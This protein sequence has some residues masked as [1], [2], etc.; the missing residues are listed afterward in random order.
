MPKNNKSQKLSYTQLNKIKLEA[1]ARGRQTVLQRRQ[2]QKQA[3]INEKEKINKM[4]QNEK[5]VYNL[6]KDLKIQ[7]QND[8]ALRK[9]IGTTKLLDK[10]KTTLS[11]NI[12][13][14]SSKAKNTLMLSIS[15]SQ[16]KPEFS[17][18]TIQTFGNNL[19]RYF[20]KI[21]LNGD[22]SLE[23]DYAQKKGQYLIKSGRL[24][25]IGNDIEFYDPMTMSTATEEGDIRLNKLYNDVD[26]FDGVKFFIHLNGQPKHIKSKINKL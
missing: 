22:I 2:A 25:D 8:N 21:G 20:K 16:F 7:K 3:E 17:R 14:R 26:S 24:T 23:T 12:N 10:F 6:N 19:S 9:M 18:K 11:D 13:L 4:T 5:L 1:L 15:P